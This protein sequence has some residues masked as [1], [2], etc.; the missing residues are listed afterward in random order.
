[1]DWYEQTLVKDRTI[2]DS[3]KL[4]VQ[5]VV[6][7][8]ER[9]IQELI[10]HETA[11][12]GLTRAT[13]NPTSSHAGDGAPNTFLDIGVLR[14]PDFQEP[15]VQVKNSLTDC[16]MPV[17]TEDSNQVYRIQ[18]TAWTE[19]NLN[20]LEIKSGIKGGECFEQFFWT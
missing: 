18:L 19:I 3:V 7:E 4:D 6:Q 8:Q 12:G 20:E 17:L 5:H 2:R 10:Q 13:S 1:M 16:Q 15:Y 9:I 14:F 11:E